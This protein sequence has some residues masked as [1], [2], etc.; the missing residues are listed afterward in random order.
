MFSEEVY[1]GERNS[2]IFLAINKSVY[3]FIMEMKTNIQQ[4]IMAAFEMYDNSNGKIFNKEKIRSLSSGFS[5]RGCLE[6][7]IGNIRIAFIRK[8][9]NVYL[10]HGF[11]KKSNKWP[12]KDKHN[13]EKNCKEIQE[14]INQ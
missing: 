13:T 5:C 6:F 3:K 14:F 1:K 9:K 4:R 12:K 10:L 2:F 11:E 7:K 8:E